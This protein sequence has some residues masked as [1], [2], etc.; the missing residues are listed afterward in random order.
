MIVGALASPVFDIE[1]YIL[2][3]KSDLT[4]SPCE[5]ALRIATPPTYKHM[6][7]CRSQRR[8]KSSRLFLALFIERNPQIKLEKPRAIHSPTLIKVTTDSHIKDADN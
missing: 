5:S 7:S 6:I 2:P 3:A 1:R 8:V 4:A